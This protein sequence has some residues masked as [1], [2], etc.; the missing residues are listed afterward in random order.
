MARFTA[1]FTV[2]EANDWLA[3]AFVRF[4]KFRDQLGQNLEWLAQSHNHDGGS[5][6]G[7]TIPTADPKYIWFIAPAGGGPFA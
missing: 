6:D 7:G 5:G 2:T 1:T 3:G 4:D